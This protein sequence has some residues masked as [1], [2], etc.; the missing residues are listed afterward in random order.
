MI[1]LAYQA[2]NLIMPVV[3]ADPIPA[4]IE[5]H[6]DRRARCGHRFDVI[7]K[8]GLIRHSRMIG[9]FEVMITPSGLLGKVELSAGLRKA[10]KTAALTGALRLENGGLDRSAAIRE[11]PRTASMCQGGGVEQP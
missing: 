3:H 2:N 5:A 4:V 7:D 11:R 6:N 8:I 9:G 1:K 10:V